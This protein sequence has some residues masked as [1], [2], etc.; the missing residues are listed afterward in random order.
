VEDRLARVVMPFAHRLD[1][2][3]E[4]LARAMSGAIEAR[5]RRLEISSRE[6]AAMS[7]EAVLARGFAVVRRSGEAE[8]G[9]AIRNAAELSAGDELA[10]SFARG[11]ARARTLE[12]GK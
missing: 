2:A 4:D 8:D 11:S 5:S 6:L 1:D 10:I 3:R 7:P 12:V 9:R